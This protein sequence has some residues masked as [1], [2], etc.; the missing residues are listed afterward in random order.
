M[1]NNNN[2]AIIRS[3]LAVLAAKNNRPKIIREF[4]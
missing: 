4:V 3:G 2:K 1:K